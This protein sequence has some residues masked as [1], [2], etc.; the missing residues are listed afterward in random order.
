MSRKVYQVSFVHAAISKTM[1]PQLSV[2]AV[3]EVSSGGWKSPEIV[4]RIYIR[5]PADGVQEFDFF[6]T[7][8]AGMAI[9]VILPISAS[10]EVERL[11]WITGVR[12]YSA[13]NSVESSITDASLLA[14]CGPVRTE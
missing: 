2:A 6:A 5:P 4:P 3:G 1:P 12:V 9:Q 7:P 11:E 8:P 14:A 10:V 13:N